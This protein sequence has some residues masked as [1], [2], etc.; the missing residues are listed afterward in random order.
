M[1]DDIPIA[2][3]HCDITLVE[4]RK[5]GEKMIKITKGDGVDCPMCETYSPTYYL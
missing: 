4:W 1:S 2:C 3:S 5:F